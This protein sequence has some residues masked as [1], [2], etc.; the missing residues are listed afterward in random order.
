[1]LDTVERVIEADTMKKFED[2]ARQ[3]SAKGVA[4]KELG[5]VCEAIVS[6]GLSVSGDK[7]FAGNNEKAADDAAKAYAGSA[8]ATV[9][10]GHGNDLVRSMTALVNDRVL[11]AD[12]KE[13]GA[14]RKELAALLERQKSILDTMVQ[15]GW[16]GT[17]K[18]PL[19][20]EHRIGQGPA[21][22][23]AQASMLRHR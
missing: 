9:L 23:S 14:D 13:A 16:E 21:G 3:T 11:Y 12:R 18:P 15:R 4:V 19:R 17:Q 2:A 10:N 20:Q 1:M 6:R 8:S 22:V 7:V 5:E